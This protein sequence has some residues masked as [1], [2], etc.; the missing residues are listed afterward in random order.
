MA[1]VSAKATWCGKK[2]RAPRRLE[3]AVVVPHYLDGAVGQFRIIPP[4]AHR[5]TFC[6]EHAVE[7]AADDPTCVARLAAMTARAGAEPCDW[8]LSRRV[9]HLAWLRAMEDAEV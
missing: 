7:H 2:R 8:L 9:A 3:V 6:D 5:C 1:K 4:G